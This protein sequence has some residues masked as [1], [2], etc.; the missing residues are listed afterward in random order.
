VDYEEPKVA[1]VAAWVPGRIDKLFVNFT[2]AHV[3]KGAPLASIYSPDLL[4][5]Q[6]EY[7]LALETR[8]RIA[9]SKNGE[10]LRGAESLVNASQKKLLL[11]G[12]SQEQIVDLEQKRETSTHMIIH[13]PIGGTV[14]HKNAS[15]GVYVKEGQNLYQIADLSRVWVLADIYEHDLSWVEKGQTAEVRTEAYLGET[16]NGKISFIDPYL[17]SRTRT[18]KVRINVPNP[19]MKIKPGMFVDVRLDAP[20]DQGITA[21]EKDVYVCPMC[22]EIISDVPA[23]CPNC[24]MDLVKKEKPPAGSI[25]AVPKDSVLQTG[26]RQL[27]YVEKEPGLYTAHMIEIGTEAV[28]HVNGQKRKFYPVLTGLS[29]GM[30]VV[31]HANFLIDSQSQI[32]GQAEAIYSGALEKHIH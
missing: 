4:T 18:V 16:F 2:G 25:L 13:A 30:K 12:I 17:D 9:K 14:I 28:A 26:K 8:D 15:E 29:E 27:V 19:E 23:D 11:W 10:T 31:S 7:L 6:E 5:A 24:G 22:P 20:I 21:S 3:R 32:T 1:F